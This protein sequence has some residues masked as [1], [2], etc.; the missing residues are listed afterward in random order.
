M[1]ITQHLSPISIFTYGSLMFAPVWQR[2]VSGHY[3][4]CPAI[5]TDYQRLAVKNEEYPVAIPAMG[6]HIEG[7][8]YYAVHAQDVLHLDEFEGEYYERTP[9]MVSTNSNAIVAASV[10]GLRPAFRHI[11]AEQAWDVDKFAHGG[12]LEAFMERYQGFH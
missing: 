2:I 10:Y 11:A 6:H 5:L 1:H 7:V 3:A 8:L 9:V 12:G 4:S